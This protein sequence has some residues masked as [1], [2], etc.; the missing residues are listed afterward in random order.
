MATVGSQEGLPVKL[1]PSL[2]RKFKALVSAGYRVTSEWTTAYNCIA[3]AA[4]DTSRKWDC[5]PVPIPG[6][7]WPPEAKTG[8]YIDA[9]ESAFEVIGFTQCDNGDLED[10]YEKVALYV[11]SNGKWTH[12]AK[13][14]PDGNWSSKLGNAEDIAHRSPHCFGGSD[15]EDVMRFMRRPLKRNE[16]G[17]LINAHTIKARGIVGHQKSSDAPD[18]TDI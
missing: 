2:E 5:T 8:D 15:Y 7:Y 10:G 4:G 13:Q 6:Y 14:L 17:E 12:A 9:L 18:S 16:K 11:D 1:D 3:Y